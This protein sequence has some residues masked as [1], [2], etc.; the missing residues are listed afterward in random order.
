MDRLR[1]RGVRAGQNLEI[2]ESA[3]TIAA[4][5]MSIKKFIAEE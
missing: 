2:S 5:L 4:T 3:S 1:L